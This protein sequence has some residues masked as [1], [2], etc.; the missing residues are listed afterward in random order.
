MKIIKLEGERLNDYR[1]KYRTL[2]GPC[3][4]DKWEAE[5]KGQKYDSWGDDAS[6]CLD[7][8]FFAGFEGSMT[9]LAESDRTRVRFV[10]D[11]VACG[12]VPQL[13]LKAQEGLTRKLNEI[14]R[15]TAKK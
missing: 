9:E 2:D 4:F 15:R 13:A 3:P 12:F 5:E 11:S 6:T 14:E 8:M 1:F 7:C 10:P